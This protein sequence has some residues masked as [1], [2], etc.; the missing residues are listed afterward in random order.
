[1]SAHTHTH[2]H[3]HIDTTGATLLLRVDLEPD[4]QWL[5]RVFDVLVHGR[6]A[7]AALDALVGREGVSA[8]LSQSLTCRCTGW[9]SSWFVPVRDTLVRMSNESLPSG[10]SYSILGHWAAGLVAA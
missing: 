7:E 3:T 2:T 6:G 5:R 8:C 10:L 4:A 1:M 9:S